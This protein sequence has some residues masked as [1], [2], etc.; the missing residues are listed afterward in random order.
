[1]IVYL[2]NEIETYITPKEKVVK[3]QGLTFI[4]VYEQEED[5][6]TIKRFKQDMFNILKATEK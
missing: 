2:K 1:M 5:E 6:M 4:N 3:F